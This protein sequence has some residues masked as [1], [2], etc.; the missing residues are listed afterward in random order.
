M[1][2]LD[3][4]RT[5]CRALLP[6]LSC[7]APAQ[8]SPSDY[9][10]ILHPL[11][12]ACAQAASQLTQESARQQLQAEEYFAVVRADEIQVEQ[13]LELQ[14]LAP[15]PLLALQERIQRL[16][17]RQE[18]L[19]RQGLQFQALAS[20]AATYAEGYC[21]LVIELQ[22]CIY[23]VGILSGDQASEVG[24]ELLLA[25]RT[26]VEQLELAVQNLHSEQ[27]LQMSGDGLQEGLAGALEEEMIAREHLER[28]PSLSM[29]SPGGQAVFAGSGV[30]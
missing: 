5:F 20:R 11:K 3:S 13:L 10:A 9:T 1:T 12:T 26:R 15:K 17:A 8:P 28:E 27:G 7:P 18:H 29:F 6:H 4:V 24:E 23:K 21:K 2:L 19:T 30:A 25:F 22:I 14:E 16:C